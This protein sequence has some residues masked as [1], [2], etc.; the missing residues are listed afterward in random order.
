MSQEPVNIMGVVA[1]PNENGQR[2]IRFI[3]SEY[4]NLFTVPDGGNIIA[5]MAMRTRTILSNGV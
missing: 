1:F 5:L 3:D 2:E 4:N